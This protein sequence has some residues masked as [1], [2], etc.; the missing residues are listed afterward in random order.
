MIFAFNVMSSLALT[1]VR[2]AFRSVVCMVFPFAGN[3]FQKF[4]WGAQ[5]IVIPVRVR[6]SSSSSPP[7]S[8]SFPIRKV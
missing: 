3:H 6:S 7:P 2:C 5:E 1:I 4:Y 8:S